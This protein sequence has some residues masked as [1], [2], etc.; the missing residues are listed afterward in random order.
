ME[1][2]AV[3]SPDSGAWAG[4]DILGLAQPLNGPDPNPW[5]LF[6]GSL[7]RAGAPGCP[8]DPGRQKA[9]AIKATDCVP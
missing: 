6:P 2:S 8:D 5:P 9:A 1:P 3:G 4:I 7:Q